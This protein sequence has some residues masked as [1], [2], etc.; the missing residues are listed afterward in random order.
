M[1]RLQRLSGSEP[2][3]LCPEPPQGLAIAFE[4]CCRKVVEFV[5]FQK[6]IQLHAR[7]KARQSANVSGSQNT[8]SIR[9]DHQALERRPGK[10]PPGLEF[11]DNV[12]GVIQIHR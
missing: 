8:R 9:F 1:Y 11:L 10:I 12:F 2:G 6:G 3:V 4:I 7:F 5:L